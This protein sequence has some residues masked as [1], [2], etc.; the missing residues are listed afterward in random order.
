VIELPTF[1][2][3]LT[4]GGHFNYKRGYKTSNIFKDGVIELPT[5]EMGLTSGYIFIIN[6]DTRRPTFS[7]TE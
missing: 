4:S 6:V 5:F 2:M 1:E 7:R 3:G